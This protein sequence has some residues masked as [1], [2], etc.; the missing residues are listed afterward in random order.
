MYLDKYLKVVIAENY[1]VTFKD[2]GTNP[3]SIYR[4]RKQVR[5]KSFTSLIR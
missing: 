1:D 3:I 4:L 5:E 2:P